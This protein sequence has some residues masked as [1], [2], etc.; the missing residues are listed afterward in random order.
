M[1][2]RSDNQDSFQGPVE[3]SFDKLR[4]QKKQQDPSPEE[5]PLLF[6]MLDQNSD[7][8]VSRDEAKGDLKENFAFVD[9]NKDGGI[10]PNELTQALELAYAQRATSDGRSSAGATAINFARPSFGKRNDKQWARMR[11]VSPDEDHE[12][13]MVNL[14]KYRAKA[15][16]ADGRQTDLTG[17]QANALYAPIKFIA[18]IG[19]KV[20]FVGQ[21]SQQ[22]GNIEPHWDEVAIVR[23]PSRSKFFEMVTNPEFQKRAVHKDAGL[24]VSQ[25]L[26]TEPV[27]WTL[28]GTK[29]VPDKQDAFTLAQLMKYRDTTKDSEV[30][31]A[32]QQRT[33]MEAMDAFDTAIEDV[34]REVGAKRLLRTRVEGALIGDGRT[35]DEFRLLHFPSEAAYT[36]YSDAVQQMPDAMKQLN[37]VIEDSYAM[38]VEPM[39]FAKRLA[40]SLATSFLGQ[41]RAPLREPVVNTTPVRAGVHRTP[42]ARFADIDDF[43]FKPHY[44]DID[45][46]RMAYV[47]EGTGENGTFLLL[48]GEPV[49][50]Y[51]YRGAIPGLA[52][53]GYRVIA[54]DNIGF[55]RSDKVIDT[56]WYTL[57]NHVRTLKRLVTKLDL[58]NIT[59]VVNDWGGPNGLVMATEMPER[60][61][62]LVIL[63]TWL[64]FDGYIYTKALRDWNKRSQ[65]IDFTNFFLFPSAVRAPYD[66]PDAVAGALRWPWMLPFAEP[67]AGNAVRQEAAW[68]NLASWKKPAH[69]IFGDSDRVFTEEWGRQF[70]AHIPGATF[71]SVKGEGHRPFL[72]TGPAGGQFTGK[73]RGDEFSKL[74]LR[75]IRNE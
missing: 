46:L 72:F 30:R 47:D 54:P 64:H 20:N 7:K 15:K 51:M 17:K 58:R 24:E 37:H 53:A 41:Q 1:V 2:I 26:L 12:F 75:L 50:S 73:H 18:Q 25:V 10:D 56:E 4:S 23:Y 43:P 3:F 71:T 35:W 70:A 55:G 68:N 65:S 63:N 67:E 33:G 21:V 11:S 28:S 45:G 8:K 5:P 6:S 27:P 74:V 29:R 49:W 9:S 16:Y 36:A 14:I 48:H 32:K 31:G 44:I 61:D 60:F 22:M 40:V 39:P 13:L 59:I 34:L 57:D 62:R 69:V 38:K 52:A 19:G 42:E 66:G